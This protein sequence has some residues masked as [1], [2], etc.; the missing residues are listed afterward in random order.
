M[1]VA[2]KTINGRIT[3]IKNGENTFRTE[4]GI[5]SR[6]LLS[7][8]PETGDIDAVNRLM[9]VLNPKN[10]ELAQKFFQTY[11]PHKWDTKELRFGKKSTNKEMV[12]K[13]RN[14]TNTFLSNESNTI[15]TWMAQKA[16]R[17]ERPAKPKDYAKKI[18]TLAHAALE[19]EK[20]AIDIKAMLRAIINA[21]AKLSDI[22]EALDEVAKEQQA[23]IVKADGKPKDEKPIRQ[24]EQPV[25]RRVAA[26]VH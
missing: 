10:K 7:Y 18:E 17:V 6:E 11:L 14:L 1:V 20:E 16:E 3:K 12:A 13:R 8:V 23:E 5:L 25:Q 19:D 22:M 24:Q 4:M 15:W 26:A 2:L 9:A 21:G